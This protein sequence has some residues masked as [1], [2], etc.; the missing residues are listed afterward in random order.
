MCL[1]FV[2]VFSALYMFESEKI[3]FQIQIQI[4]KT[5]FFILENINGGERITKNRHG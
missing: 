3:R 1:F 5:F 2:R 4:K